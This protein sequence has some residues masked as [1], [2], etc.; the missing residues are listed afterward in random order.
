M[1]TR[2]SGILYNV[3]GPFTRVDQDGHTVT[4]STYH[5]KWL[6]IYFG[7]TH[8]PDVCPTALGDMAEAL[9]GLGPLR[10]KAR[11]YSSPSTRSATHRW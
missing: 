7:Y 3:G 6:L 8:C 5:G 1:G 9:A 4:D 10:A 2:R 11:R